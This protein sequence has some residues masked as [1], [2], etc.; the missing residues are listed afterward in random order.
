LYFA[1]IK[2]NNPGF[3]KNFRIVLNHLCLPASVADLGK[4]QR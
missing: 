3:D 1:Y 2:Y 4:Y